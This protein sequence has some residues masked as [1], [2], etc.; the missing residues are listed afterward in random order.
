MNEN[1]E[2]LG[3]Y[4]KETQYFNF[5]RSGSNYYISE[6]ITRKGLFTAEWKV[7]PKM[8]TLSLFTQPHVVPILHV[9]IFCFFF[10]QQKYFGRIVAQ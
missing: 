3:S 9:V 5:T 10:K 8:E 7:Y 1:N 2:D 6:R 4:E